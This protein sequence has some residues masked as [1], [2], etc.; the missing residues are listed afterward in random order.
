MEDSK[1]Y[2]NY[3][4]NI[5]QKGGES[6]KN[7]KYTKSEQRY[8]TEVEKTGEY[9]YIRSYRKGDILPNG[10]VVGDN[11]YIKIKH[12]YCGSIYEVIANNFIN[13]NQRC[14]KCCG[15]YEGSFAY[16]IEVELGEPLEKYWDFEKNTVNPYHI[17]K[18]SDKKTIGRVWIRCQEKNYHGS[19]EISCDNFLKG[20]TCPYCSNQKVHPKDSFAQYH[21][22]N[23]DPNFLEKY[24]SDK[25]TL[26]PW[27]I[28]PGSNNNVW[29]VC[30]EKDYHEDYKISCSRFKRN[31]NGCGSCSNR[32]GKVHPLDSFGYH[33]FDKVMSWHPDNDISP[34]RV[35]PNSNKKY[36][37]I[38]ETCGYEW[39]SQPSKINNERWCPQ[40]STSKG[41]KRISKWLDYNN[42]KY[43]NQKEFN[44]LI[45]VGGKNLS[46]DFYLPDYNLLI[47]YQGEQH[48]KYRPGFHKNKESFMKQ[49][50]H[51]RR[52]RNYAEI[53]DVGLLEIWYWDF[54][55][56]EVILNKEL[57]L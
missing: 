27:K 10:K 48:E 50:E 47:E 24:W 11:P 15:S 28:S 29:I 18:G 37:F 17:S 42:V 44:G 1:I 57:K 9:E 8:K 43:L 35:A 41:E 55:N 5:V 2:Y 21:I 20:N 56:I 7:I 4:S 40:C 39:Y 26:N 6:M 23:T 25:N 31:N 33:H 13:A 3:N 22:D 49:Q 45:G 53:N 16:H 46:Y 51:D 36:K 14:G 52:K 34:F 30:Q 38:C 54:E 32:P 19:Y 12:K